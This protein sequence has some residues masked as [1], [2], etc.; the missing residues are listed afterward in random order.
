MRLRGAFL[1]AALSVLPFVAQAQPIQGLYVA[2]G[3]GVHMPQNTRVSP[4]S[5]AFGGSHLRMTQDLG[6]EVLGSL[7]YALGNGARFEIEGD[8]NQ[9]GLRQLGRTG[10]PATASG[11]VRHYGVMANALFDMDIGLP[12]LYP[13]L[14]VGAGYQWTSLDR[15]AV[16]QVGGPF[17]FRANDKVGGV[18]VQAI[19]GTSFPIPNMPGLSVTPEYRFMDILGG[20]KIT[21]TTGGS[22]ATQIKL[23]NQFDHNFLIGVRYAF[24]AP[25]PAVAAPSASPAPAAEASRSY[26]VFFDW[27]QA[28]L[29]TRARAIVK[30][31]ADNAA[32]VQHTRIDVN[33]NAD[34]SGTP[35]YNQDL[36]M[37]R[38]Q[39]VAAELV[40]DGI[41]K[42]A[43]AITAAGET[44]PLV[45]TGPGVREPRNRRVEIVLH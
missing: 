5:A 28:T 12:W 26:L 11:T 45:P 33:G 31:A 25:P 22:T 23:H 9:N 19:I 4:G 27:D 44:K 21:G 42:S 36:S 7:G 32:R 38:A 37:R 2:S 15:V 20:G 34:T 13:Y 10:F 39:T 1:A 24:N 35:A 6:F 41:E 16:N 30:E 43:I 29:S 14:G 40:K 18:A 8:F 3:V 17:T